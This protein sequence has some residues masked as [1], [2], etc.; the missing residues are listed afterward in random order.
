MQIDSKS[1][2]IHE[3]SA[4]LN[5]RERQHQ[6]AKRSKHTR[7][8]YL[9][10]YLFIILSCFKMYIVASLFISYNRVI[11]HTRGVARLKVH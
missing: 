4:E 2:L 11:K 10:I 5:S 7:T 6:Q 3:L 1:N 8:C 9:F